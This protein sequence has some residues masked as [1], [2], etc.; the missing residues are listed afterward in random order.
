M[1]LFRVSAFASMFLL[2]L[3]AGREPTSA[4]PGDHV[5]STGF[6]DVAVQRAYD[7]ALD[8]KGN[9]LL[10]GYFQGAVDFGGG[11]LTS[12]GTDD[13]FLA[14]F[15][16]AGNHLWS[17]RFGDG[18]EQRAYAMATD[19][20]G[21]VI[22][23]GSVRGTADFGGGSLTSAGAEDIFIAKFDD[24][25]NHLWSKI[26]GDATDLQISTT[27]AV[28]ASDNVVL[29]GPM[30]GS[31]DFGGG[32]RVSAG[33]TDLFI[34]KFDSA[35]S[36]LWSERFGDE[37]QQFGVHT[38][39]D[40]SG[41]I[42]LAGTFAGALDLGGG[43]LTSSGSF[44][45]YAA[46]LDGSGDHIWSRQFG[47][48][49]TQHATSIAVDG[50]NN[51]VLT[52]HFR[53]TVDFGGGLLT[54]A[55]DYD[56]FLVKLD[57]SGDHVWSKRFGDY[58]LQGALDVAADVFGNVVVIPHVFGTAD[59]GEGPLTSAGSFDVALARF[60][61]AGHDVWSKLFGDASWQAGLAVVAN[62]VDIVIA[63][64]FGGSV[65]FG[66]GQL[67]STGS[68]DIFLAKFEECTD[69][70]NADSGPMPPAENSGTFA[71]G[72]GVPGEDATIPNGD[73][74]GDACDED[75]DNDGL[76]DAEE[77][78]ATACAPF[79]L[80]GTAHPA[81]AGGDIT[82]DDDK[83]GNPAPF[84]GTDTGDDG[85]SW[86]TDNDGILDGWECANGYDPRDAGSRPAAV[87]GDVDTDGDGLLD[88]WEAR[89]WGTDPGVVDS[90][91]D[92]LG[93][94]QEAADVDGNGVVNFSGDVIYFAMAALVPSF[95]KT[96]DFDLD[97][98]GFV[99]FSGDVIT[100]ARF[101]LLAGLCE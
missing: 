97:K 9:V 67:T 100:A 11:P 42:L 53:G 25:G 61:P 50:A 18:D 5:W 2:A 64:E 39:I 19:S 51:V 73:G 16:T 47:D 6:G 38:A 45:G 55:G 33:S 87:M 74:L 93:D 60:D 81:P 35:G 52:G 95:G 70:V 30:A 40:A 44:D 36:H 14:K 98:N 3:T 31:V 68:L 96:Q 22:V 54:S 101:A 82:N 57:R 23:I 46:K 92:G 7:V 21:N 59:F 34:A 24:E 37:D 65:D 91:G 86:D 72:P 83:N 27:V 62:G 8:G 69:Q 32:A 58:N 48:W 75:N 17:Q 80:S 13:I 88:S 76:P 12:A 90:D 85:P 1:V 66:G 41:D 79:D 89:G 43:P 99:N 4:A 56:V 71:N 29:A 28:D 20:T 49:D 10:T 15:D 77:L 94:C 84:M 26:F 63:G 78:S